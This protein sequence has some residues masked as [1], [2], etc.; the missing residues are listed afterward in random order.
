MAEA[1]G[2]AAAQEPY[3]PY[4]LID[5]MLA[6]S[7]EA[8]ALAGARM[9]LRTLAQEV[10]RATEERIGKLER[11]ERERRKAEAHT[12]AAAATASFGTTGRM[13]NGPSASASGATEGVVPS[14]SFRFGAV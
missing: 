8:E 13:A 5:E 10:R 7:E 4:T 3:I 6:V 12:A 1:S 14:D 9:E 11:S 2:A